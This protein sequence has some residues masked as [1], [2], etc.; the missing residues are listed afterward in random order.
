MEKLCTR[1]VPWPSTHV[2]VKYTDIL[3]SLRSA[4]LVRDHVLNFNLVFPKHIKPQTYP[5]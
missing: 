2:P 3:K 1:R 4:Y 5:C